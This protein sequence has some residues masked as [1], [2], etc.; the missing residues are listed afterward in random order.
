[1]F[2]NL[3][4][5]LISG[6]IIAILIAIIGW[7]IHSIRELNKE[8]SRLST[9]LENINFEIKTSK[10]KDGDYVFSVN[11]LT[12]KVNELQN[13][14]KSLYD[15]VANMNLKLKNLQSV[16]N[17]SYEINNKIDR[18]ESEKVD[19]PDTG[20]LAQVNIVSKAGTYKFNRADKYSTFKGNIVVPNDAVSNP[21]LSDIDYTMTDSLIIANEFKY[22]RRWIFWKK[23]TGVETH[24]KSNN[25]N[26][27]VNQMQSF[28]VTK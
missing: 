3:K 10:T 19:T 8:N 13:I 20:D 5:I 15:D 27:K 4:T 17:V 26:F 21:Y 24:V 7:N 9:N 2:A 12:T 16:A 11:A 14:N 22:K 25:P 23:V 28:Q 18:I 6:G 1:M